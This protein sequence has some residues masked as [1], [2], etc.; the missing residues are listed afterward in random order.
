[1]NGN[2]KLVESNP[3]ATR[4]IAMPFIRWWHARPRPFSQMLLLLCYTHGL[5][6]AFKSVFDIAQIDLTFNTVQGIAKLFH[7]STKLGRLLKEN[8]GGKAMVS[9]CN[10][11]FS[12]KF[13]V[14]E[15]SYIVFLKSPYNELNLIDR[16]DAKH[17]AT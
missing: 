10:T 3:V 15:P 12:S 6:N 5:N 14:I 8:C 7:K 9:D 2:S 4:L 17:Q 16:L 13:F 1:M 11:R